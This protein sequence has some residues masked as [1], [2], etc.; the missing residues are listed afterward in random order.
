MRYLI[1]GVTPK[2]ADEDPEIADYYDE[3]E[4]LVDSAGGTVVARFLQNRREPDPRTYVGTGFAHAVVERILAG[5]I[6]S[7]ASDAASPKNL[8]PTGGTDPL[9]D[10]EA[11]RDDRE[12]DDPGGA[13][14]LGGTPEQAKA[15]DRERARQVADAILLA[16]EVPPRMLAGLSDLFPLPVLDRTGLILGIFAD[17]ARSAEGRLE[18]EL[19]EYV[20]RLPRLRGSYQALGRQRGGLG[21]RGGSGE[22]ALELDRRRVRRRIGDL[23]EELARLRT[24]RTRRRES[25]KDLPRVSLV[26]YTNAGKTTL[27]SALTGHLAPGANRLFDTL[28]P[29]TRRL[30]LDGVGEVLL[31]DTVG[32]VRELPEGLLDAFAATLE[33]VTESDL[34]LHVVNGASLK[35]PGRIRAV[36]ELLNRLGA[37]D[38]PEITVFTHGDDGQAG[39]VLCQGLVTKAASVDSVTGEGLSEL[40]ALLAD[41][42]AEGREEVA[43]QLGP[44]QWRWVEFARRHGEAQITPQEDGSVHLTARLTARDA[45]IL[46]DAVRPREKV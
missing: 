39:R 36:R 12:R 2:G 28:D 17:R 20:Y 37:G 32:F 26:G 27:V 25:R 14:A 40:R 15:S 23:R 38:V 6:G 7:V 41:V 42:L 46:R 10:R 4:S 8:W 33:E 19:A 5:R 34:L 3:L 22:T 13:D 9:P 30:F 45:A 21:L 18:V 16:E 1:L 43:L 44:D 29:T 35:A 24:D 11:D 31:T